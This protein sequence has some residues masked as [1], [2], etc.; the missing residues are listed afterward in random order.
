MLTY[1]AIA[2]LLLARTLLVCAD[3]VETPDF[4]T[5][6][7]PPPYNGSVRSNFNAGKSMN[8]T[9]VPGSSGPSGLVS[10]RLLGGESNVTI[11]PDIAT[12]IHR[13]VGSFNWTI[14]TILPVYPFYDLEIVL[15][16]N[17]SIFSQAKSFFTIDLSRQAVTSSST[18]ISS[19][20]SS[21]QSSSQASST[22]LP[23]ATTTSST[24][25]NTQSPSTGSSLSTGAKAGI[26]VGAAA[27]GIA[28]LALLGIFIFRRGK[29][30]ATQAEEASK[31]AADKPLTVKERAELDDTR[32]AAELGA[33]PP[34]QM[35]EMAGGDY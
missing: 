1:S 12:G 27:G 15:T 8:I 34:S 20:S 29:R 23:P 2:F 19:T 26:G 14:P 10:I 6:T 33:Y 7:N 5:F 28:I 31:V 21:T 13:N 25:T 16:T 11:A 22:S 24:P 35:H 3:N 32:R 30:A 9:W 4:I 17:D 18:S